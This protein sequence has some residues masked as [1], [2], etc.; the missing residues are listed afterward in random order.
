MK[1]LVIVHGFPPA[2]QGGAEIY[3]HAHAGAL[4]D[5]FGDEIVVLTREQDPG[6][7]EYAVRTETRDGLHIVWINNT[8]RNTRG[9]QETYR[10]EA[11]GA[12]ADRVIDDFGPAVAHVHH[13]TCLSTT[14][15]RSLATR[16]IPC[17]MTLHD[18]WL[19]CHRGQLL[20][21]NY[22]I[23]A[24]VTNPVNLAN[25]VNVANL[26]NPCHACL[27]PAGGAGGVGFLGAAAVRAIERGLPAGPARQLRRVAGRLAEVTTSTVRSDD[28]ARRRLAHMR[29]VS[30]DVTHFI[31]PSRYLRDRFVQ[32]GVESERI[33]VSGYGFDQPPLARTART[34]SDRLRLGFLGSLMASKAPHVLI[35][36]AGRLP[37]DAVSVDLFGA[38]S[39][40]HGDDSYRQRLEPLL[41]QDVVRAHGAIAHERVADAL[42]SIDVLVVPSIWPENSPLVIQEAFLAGVP[43][44]ASRIGGISE[45]VEEG[46]HGLLFDAGDAEDLART[47]TRLLREPDLLETL[48][49]GIPAVRT[50]EDDVRFSRDLYQVHL[51]RISQR[52]SVRLQADRAPV[53]LKP[54]TTYYAPRAEAGLRSVSASSERMAA[55]VLNYRT[56]DDTLLAVRSLLASKRPL[57]EVIVVDND[58]AGS[59]REAL[60][61]V[62]QKI[63]YLPADRNLG[64]SGGMNVGIRDALS[65]GAARVLLVNSDV[66]VPP[67]CVGRLEERLAAAPRVGIVGPVILSR[68]TPDQVESLGM[69]YS[70]RTGRMRHRLT[71]HVWGPPS[72]GP[73]RLKPD[74]T[75]VDAVSGCLMLVSREVFEVIGLLDEDYFFSFEDVDFCLKARRAGFATVLAG[76]AT[77]YHEGSRSI[78]AA[79]PER[80]YFAA[81]NHLLMAELAEPSIGRL[82]RLGRTCSIVTLNIAHAVRA[83]GGSLPARLA[84]VVRGTRDYVRGRFGNR[85]P[86]SRFL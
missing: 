37:P 12:I 53:R 31:A 7:P 42:A 23:C 59:A 44:V 83:R 61:G 63:R 81:R 3:A 79:G 57:D 64:F 76:S 65:R 2:A 69:S 56:P 54:D 73:I 8:F 15:V 47:L 60:Q 19:M 1:I 17:F 49:R 71:T 29:E 43:V 51:A 80:L 26:A 32:W 11:I 74:L 75:P 78:G 70:Q 25:P 13:L 85:S 6:R 21:T 4:R 82:A 77:V 39:A 66:I 27:G 33:T 58:K 52:S 48:R 30:A 18:Y 68:S 14:I 41:K 84:A 38:Y 45:V 22:Q 34:P 67:D 9:F 10:N 40:Y 72:G 24:K 5:L 28:Q 62:W 35:E 46:R 86:S 16:R 55:V 36:A 50:I 20:D